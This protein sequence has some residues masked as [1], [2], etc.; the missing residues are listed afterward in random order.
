[1]SAWVFLLWFLKSMVIAMFSVTSTVV[2]AIIYIKILSTLNKHYGD[3]IRKILAAF[4]P[5]IGDGRGNSGQ[6][7]DWDSYCIYYFD[8]VYR[9]LKQWHSRVIHFIV[10]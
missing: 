4:L 9:K 5:E 3:S 2:I 1:M 8:H 10:R 7:S 6:D